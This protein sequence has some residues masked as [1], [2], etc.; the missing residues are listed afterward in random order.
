MKTDP[1]ETDTVASRQDL[2]AFILRLRRDLLLHPE[3]WESTTLESYLEALAAHLDCVHNVYANFDMG[4]DADVASWR[5]FAD[6]LV[7]A[8]VQE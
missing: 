5:V 4:V 1:L 2:A 8:S 6:V 3:E 7:G